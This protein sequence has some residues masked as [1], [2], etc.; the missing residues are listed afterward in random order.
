M[1]GARRGELGQALLVLGAIGL[2]LNTIFLSL[3]WISFDDRSNTASALLGLSVVAACLGGWLLGSARTAAAGL[4][5]GVFC[6]AL[7]LS[8]AAAFAW[9]K[10]GY[11]FPAR[12]RL[13]LRG[14]CGALLVSAAVLAAAL[15]RRRI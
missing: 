2:A 14:A 15:R 5:A 11:F 12:S 10:S 3:D 1:N 6:A 13:L 9:L 8:A 4:A 7:F